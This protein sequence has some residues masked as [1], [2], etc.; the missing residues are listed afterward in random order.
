MK[1]FKTGR[2]TLKG[3]DPVS[4]KTF[5]INLQ[6][7]IEEASAQQVETVKDAI[8]RLTLNPTETAQ[9]NYV[10]DFV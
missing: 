7:L 5:T 8:N 1:A 9:A 10:Y 3:M 4:E 2:L 6:G